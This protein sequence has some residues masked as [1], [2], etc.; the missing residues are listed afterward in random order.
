MLTDFFK[1]KIINQQIFEKNLQTQKPLIMEVGQFDN[2]GH[3]T[4]YGK[5]KHWPQLICHVII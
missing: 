2:N 3:H 1:K 5:N 4:G